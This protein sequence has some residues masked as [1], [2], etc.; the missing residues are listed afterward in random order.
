[1][2]L[3][4]HVRL[5][6]HLNIKP[7]PP[8]TASAA[9]RNAGVRAASAKVI[10]GKGDRN[11]APLARKLVPLLREGMLLLSDCA[12]DAAGLLATIA[13]TPGRT[14]WSAAAPAASPP[15]W[16][17]CPAGPTCHRSMV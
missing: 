11:E 8:R 10:D 1:V 3:F 13:A 2:A 9:C 14:C 5:C 6:G 15:S 4:G 7:P 17:S 16:T 12:Y